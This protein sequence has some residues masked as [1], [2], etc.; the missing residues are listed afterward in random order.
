[1]KGAL[2]SKR[3]RRRPSRARLLPAY[4]AL[5]AAALLSSCA[6]KDGGWKTPADAESL[7]LLE[8]ET[9]SPRV[10]RERRAR[11]FFLWGQELFAASRNP[12]GSP[13]DSGALEGAIGAFERVVDLHS[14]LVDESRFN[15]ELLYRERERREENKSP[16]NEQNESRDK[17][18]ENKQGGNDSQGG[19]SGKKSDA[20]KNGGRQNSSSKDSLTQ[21]PSSEKNGDEG[22]SPKGASGNAGDAKDESGAP[23]PSSSPT[24]QKNGAKDVSSLVREKQGDSAL[25]DALRAES[26]RQDEKS[27]DASGQYVPVEKDW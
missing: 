23:S 22:N 6:K 10:S 3:S 13:T 8:R 2:S 1:M 4:C 18:E 11:L 19:S 21:T 20:A 24:G 5:V 26:E 14:A 9:L 7:G 27:K 17:D 25:D 16:A 12:S 15:L